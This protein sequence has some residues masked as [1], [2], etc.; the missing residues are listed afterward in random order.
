MAYDGVHGQVVLFGGI[1]G[2]TFLGDTWTWDGTE[3]TQHLG[4]SIGLRPRSGPPGASVR[5]TGWGFAAGELVNITFAD[6]GQGR[7]LLSRVQADATGS[8]ITL[9]SIPLT[10]TSGRQHV[11]A[12]GL[13][14]RELAR[15][16]FI[17]K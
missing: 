12:R 13:T 6:V 8:F 1:E 17:V 14:S 15:Q 2:T 11:K 7:T 3:W 4:G 10:A 5:V 9:V 16:G